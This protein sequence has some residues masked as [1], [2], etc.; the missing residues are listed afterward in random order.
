MRTENWRHWLA[1][2]SP[3]GRRG[4][5]SPY[6]T[7]SHEEEEGGAT[8]DENEHT[9]ANDEPGPQNQDQEQNQR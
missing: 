2:C 5:A 8:M 9:R 4:D 3:L 7:A 6:Q 1:F